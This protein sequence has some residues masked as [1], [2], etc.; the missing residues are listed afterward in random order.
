MGR[1]RNSPRPLELAPRRV[2][3]WRPVQL[4]GFRPLSPRI[5]GLSSGGWGPRFASTK[6]GRNISGDMG[7]S[8]I[9]R[10]TTREDLT[11]NRLFGYEDSVL[12]AKYGTLVA[13]NQRFWLV[14][15]L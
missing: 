5:L 10:A 3:P 14:P 13:V 6:E 12:L 11:P 7:R 2:V 4:G 15:H 1:S 9:S 8:R